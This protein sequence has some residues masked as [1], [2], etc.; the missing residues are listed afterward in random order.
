MQ[1]KIHVQNILMRNFNK[2]VIGIGESLGNK[3]KDDAIQFLGIYIDIHLT[4]SV[5]KYL[6]QHLSPIE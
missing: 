3:N 4:E 5:Q 2:I 1:T 6:N